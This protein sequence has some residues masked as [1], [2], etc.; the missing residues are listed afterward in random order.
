MKDFNVLKIKTETGERCC[1]IK[2]HKTGIPEYY[3]NI[4][5]SLLSHKGRSFNTILRVAYI[6]VLFKRFLLEN[7]IF[8]KDRLENKSFLNY[9][10]LYSLSSF[11]RK[12]GREKKILHMDNPKKMNDENV[13]YRLSIIS[14]FIIWQY[15][16]FYSN[17]LIESSELT[18]VFNNFVRKHK[19]KLGSNNYIGK[20]ENFKSLEEEQTN[21]LF[22]LLRIDNKLNPFSKNNRK[23]NLLMVYILNETGMRG[24]ELL[25]LRIDDFIKEKQYLKITKRKDEVNEPRVLQPFVKTLERDIPISRVLVEMISNYIED[26]RWYKRSKEHNYLFI[27]QKCGPSEGLPLSISGYHKIMS[28]IQ[29]SSHLNHSFRNFTGHSLRHTWNHRYNEKFQGVTSMFKIT[30]LEQIRCVRMGWKL[31]SKSVLTYNKRYI[32]NKA[33]EAIDEVDLTKKIDTKKSEVS[34]GRNIEE[35]RKLLGIRSKR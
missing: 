23:R 12:K 18:T 26:R 5:L 10:E 17:N 2:N 25:N 19:P 1:I 33:T 8:L 9:T 7:R 22:E 15:S 24:G 31:N 28:T 4:Y 35:Y 30:E 20:N 13:H 32:Y 21:E 11:L 14:D 34:D 29:N 3:E 6:L 16:A 27:T